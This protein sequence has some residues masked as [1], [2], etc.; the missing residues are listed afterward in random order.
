M[1]F[2]IGYH[3]TVSTVEEV[4]NET[5]DVFKTFLAQRLESDGYDVPG[6]IKIQN[7]VKSDVAI[8]LQRIGDDLTN[9]TGINDLIGQIKVTPDT[10]YKTFFS[11]AMQLFSDGNVNWGRIVALF[12]FAYRLA[13]QCI[14]NM[15]LLQTIIGWVGKFVYDKLATW[16][17]ERGGWSAIKEW[18]G[19]TSAQMVGV[20]L[21]G[22]IFSFGI[23]WFKK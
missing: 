3:R 18:F 23:L 7:R 21:A 15:S 17:S 22:M 8:T 11:V 14:T 6:D 12:Y 19:S 4:S 9:N 13:L 20:F 5:H 16:I 1:N 10:V 2:N